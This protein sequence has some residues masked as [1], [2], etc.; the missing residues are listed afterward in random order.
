[1][2]SIPIISVGISLKILHALLKQK[3]KNTLLGGHSKQLLIDFVKFLDFLYLI[4]LA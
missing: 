1:M 4:D 2:E 3:V